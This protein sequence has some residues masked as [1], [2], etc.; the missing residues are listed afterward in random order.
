[1]QMHKDNA[2]ALTFIVVQQDSV[3]KNIEKLTSSI[4]GH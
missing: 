3:E 2:N 4:Q 1:M